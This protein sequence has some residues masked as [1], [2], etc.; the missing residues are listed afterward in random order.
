MKTTNRVT[1]KGD[2][3]VR[4][5]QSANTP[6][7]KPGKPPEEVI[8]LNLWSST[9]NKTVFST[10]LPADLAAYLRASLDPTN[11]HPRDFIIRCLRESINRDESDFSLLAFEETIQEA[12]AMLDLLESKLLAI[13]RNEM[14]RGSCHYNSEL[15][16]RICGYMSLIG[17]AVKALHQSND[18]VTSFVQA[19][20]GAR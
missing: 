5:T 6:K 3:K 2:K 13:Y 4:S 10:D 11:N 15:T 14:T 1:R 9:E 8:C 20:G 16:D 7:N 17:H 19:K 18:A 12:T